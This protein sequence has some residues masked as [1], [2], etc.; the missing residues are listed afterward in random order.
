MDSQK[1]ANFER[2]LPDKY[3]F[4]TIADWNKIAAEHMEIFVGSD[5]THFAGNPE[6]EKLYLEMLQKAIAEAKA[7]PVKSNQD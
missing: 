1:L 7:K 5:T 4:I 6:G 3:D 2:T